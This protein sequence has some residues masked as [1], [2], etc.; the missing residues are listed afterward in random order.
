MSLY[1]W[2]KR[3]KFKSVKH[4]NGGNYAS[5]LG[6]LIRQPFPPFFFVSSFIGDHIIQLTFHS[7]LHSTPMNQTH[8]I[9][10]SGQNS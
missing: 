3:K 8:S 6:Y 10:L 5:D 7:L 1:T 4:V 2:A 9:Y